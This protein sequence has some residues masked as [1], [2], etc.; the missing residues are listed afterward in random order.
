MQL[1][2]STRDGFVLSSDG[3]SRASLR[4]ITL[5]FFFTKSMMMEK[6]NVYDTLVITVG[7]KFLTTM[8]VSLMRGLYRNVGYRRCKHTLKRHCFQN[9][10]N[11][12]AN[13]RRIIFFNK[14]TNS[15]HNDSRCGLRFGQSVVENNLQSL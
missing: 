7:P 14:L 6:P 11:S 12:S 15:K 8:L 10:Q 5:F 9:T 2:G 4:N 13:T 3:C 1:S